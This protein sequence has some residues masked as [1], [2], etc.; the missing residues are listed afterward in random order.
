MS[1]STFRS[2]FPALSRR[3]LLKASGADPAA[4]K[5][6]LSDLKRGGMII[7]D[8]AEFTKRNLAKVGY[9]TN[10]LEDGS[11][12]GYHIHGIDLTGLTVAAVEPFGL[13]RK[14]HDLIVH[15]QHD[16]IALR[17]RQQLVVDDVCGE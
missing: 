8:T 11:L 17:N 9:A 16:A 1:K 15:L 10:P 7:A 14:E 4:L 2:A 12:A 3:N 5:A 6:N 13:G